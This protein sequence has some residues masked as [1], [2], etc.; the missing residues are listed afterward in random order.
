M[1]AGALPDGTPVIIS[2]GYRRTVRVWRLAD[3][4]TVGSRCAA[5]AAG[6]LG[7]GRGA[8]GWHPGHHQR[9]RR[10]A[11]CGCGGPPDGT[12][13]G[14]PLTRPDQRVELGGGR[15]A[16]GRHPG[17]HQ[18]QRAT[19]RY[20]VATARRSPDRRA[21]TGHAP[22]LPRWRRGPCRTAPR[23]LS[24]AAGTGPCGYGGCPMAPR[25]G[26]PLTGHDARL[27]RWRRGRC[28]TAPRSSSAAAARRDGT[29]LAASRRHPSRRAANRPHRQGQRGNGRDA[30]GRHPGH[31]DPAAATARC[32][33]GGRPTAPRSR[34]AGRP[35][36][37]SVDR[38]RPGSCR[39]APGISAK[40]PRDA[41]HVAD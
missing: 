24:A 30:P 21:A 3:G 12:P 19:A 35:Q 39:T 37:S 23:S 40:A 7:G 18:R 31:H 4:T 17:R 28:R 22:P 16:A 33:C 14:E 34:T 13:V 38:W 8:A 41:E 29:G 32:R 6:D 15:G 1:A 9:R 2:G 10:R 26:E 11:R 20:G 27:P 36:R 25:P 5:T